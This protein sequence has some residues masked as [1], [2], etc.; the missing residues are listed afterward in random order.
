[1]GIELNGL[2]FFLVAIL[3]FLLT[4]F[5]SSLLLPKCGG[6]YIPICS[7]APHHFLEAVVDISPFAVHYYLWKF[8]S[9][10]QQQLEHQRK[11][12]DC[13]EIHLIKFL[14]LKSRPP[15][16]A[17][18]ATSRF[19]FGV[20]RRLSNHWGILS[21]GIMKPTDCTLLPD[22]FW[23]ICELLLKLL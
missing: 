10:N 20:K 23:T 19:C 3:V 6:W 1:M 17:V 16:C 14:L 9:P 13:Q 22:I 8:C 4:V 7:A 12:E 15:V 5:F 11:Q 21:S 18:V 2:C